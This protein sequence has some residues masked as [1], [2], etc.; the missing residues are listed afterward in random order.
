MRP[1]DF[2]IEA[3]RQRLYL[4]QPTTNLYVWL[5]EDTATSLRI[6]AQ[7]V[8]QHNGWQLWHVTYQDAFK[9]AATVAALAN[10]PAW[11]LNAAPSWQS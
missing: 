8:E 5:H 4:Q 2:D 7:L 11:I 9:T 6:R 3:I 10:R 1:A